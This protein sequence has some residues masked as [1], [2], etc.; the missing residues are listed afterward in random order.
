[1]TTKYLDEN[2]EIVSRETVF[3]RTPYNYDVDAASVLTG[4]TCPEE[5]KTQ[6]QFKEES[7]IN[8]IVERF[9]LTGEVPSDFRVPL[10]GDFTEHANDFHS[11]LNLILESERE[12][13]RLPAEV[14]NRFDNDPQ[15]LLDFVEDAANIDEARALGIANAIPEPV[16]PMR[17]EV[18]NPAPAPVPVP[19]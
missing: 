7:D 8:T 17:V 5:T 14:R 13:M 2:G 16:A 10:S 15:K 6:Q 19:T 12:F 1:M 9:G 4:L 3:L 11:A 18:V